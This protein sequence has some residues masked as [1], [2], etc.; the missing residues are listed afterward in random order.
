MKNFSIISA[1]TATLLF[2]GCASSDPVIVDETASNQIMRS[3]QFDTQDAVEAASEMSESLLRAGVL[4]QDGR[5]SVIAISRFINNSSQQVD[6][7]AVLKR[8]RVALNQAGVAQTMTSIS[9]DGTTQDAEDTFSARNRE[10]G[11]GGTVATLTPDYTLTFKLL[12]DVIRADDRAQ[13]T[14]IFQ[15]SLT[16]QRTGLAAWEDEKRIITQGT[17][18]TIGW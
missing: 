14:Y 16:D 9:S 7:D 11:T 8:I 13:I 15:M 4:G 1:L 12:E 10:Q 5:P 2:A 17:Q 6:R 3:L 18:G